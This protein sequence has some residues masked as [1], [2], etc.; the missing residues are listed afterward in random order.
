M[1]WSGVLADQVVVVG[2]EVAG[3]T[4]GEAVDVLEAG[5]H[6][7][8]RHR[9]VGREAVEQVAL[10]DQAAH[11]LI[12]GEAPVVQVLGRVDP[13]GGGAGREDLLPVGVA[14]R[15]EGGAPRLVQLV[16]VAVAVAQ[17]AAEGVGRDVAVA[18]GVVAAELVVDVPQD[19][20]RVS[21]EVLGELLDQSELA[22]PDDRRAR[23]E[24][25]AGPGI[26]ATAVVV[27]GKDLGIAAAQ[28]GRWRCGRCRQVDRDARSVQQAEDVV[29]LVEG[30]RPL[31]RL[32]PS[33]REDADRDQGDAGL[34]HEA[35]VLVPGLAGPLLRVVVTAVG[36][37]STKIEP[38]SHGD[39]VPS[40]RDKVNVNQQLSIS[41]HKATT[42]HAR[43]RPL[44]G[45]PPACGN[46]RGSHWVATRPDCY[47][48]MS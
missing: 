33:P 15:P 40:G 1:W 27:D 12:R 39:S 2:D 20:R 10:R 7:V 19:E 4:E 31:A 34:A 43:H 3:P 36:Q 45:V 41:A 5:Q 38:R 47:L 29:E 18:V 25:L 22:F 37:P 30:V 35:D 13:A 48:R 21:T 11:Q 23:A 42:S 6:Q 26:Q 9:D 46:H 32:E 28:P 44:P 17:P 24:R 8:G 14:L 16:E